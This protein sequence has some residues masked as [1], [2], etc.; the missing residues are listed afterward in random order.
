[1]LR[2]FLKS[3]FLCGL[4]CL[5]VPSLAS[6]SYGFERLE[7]SNAAENV[8]GQFM[9][10]VLS[11]VDA[12]SQFLGLDIPTGNILFTVTNAVGVSSSISEVYFE[13]NL[14]LFAGAPTIFNSL[15]G[16]TDYANGPIL[17]IFPTQTPLARHLRR[18]PLFQ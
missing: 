8:A 9:V 12:E 2:N 3:I 16:S 5:P 1:M 14:S 7:P 10:E 18:Q 17:A 15:G 13:D 6:N 11:E 4:V